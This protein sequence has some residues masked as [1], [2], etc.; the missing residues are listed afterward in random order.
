MVRCTE[1]RKVRGR[2]EIVTTKPNVIFRRGKILI[3]VDFYKKLINP[4]I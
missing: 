2:Q 3:F 1:G 4:I